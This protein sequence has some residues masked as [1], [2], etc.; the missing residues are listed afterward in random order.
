MDL[1]FRHVMSADALST[2]GSLLTPPGSTSGIRSDPT[3]HRPATG[4]D[5]SIASPEMEKTQPIPTGKRRGG[6]R[7][8]CNEC[9]Q[10][11]VSPVDAPMD[12]SM[13]CGLKTCLVPSAPM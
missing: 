10:Q 4:L 7:K 8:A 11:K 3:L 13:G 6:S 1:Q 5:L 12:G 2:R 9:K